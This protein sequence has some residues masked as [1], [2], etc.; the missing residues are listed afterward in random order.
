MNSVKKISV[1]L[2]LCQWLA[3]IFLIN[4][5]QR[6]HI[7]SQYKK[8][9]CLIEYIKNTKSD[10]WDKFQPSTETM[11]EFI[12]TRYYWTF[13][14]FIFCTTVI[15][16]INWRT[17][18]AIPN[19]IIVFI[20]TFLL[21]PTGFFNKGIVNTFLNSFGG[22]FSDNFGVENFIGGITFTIIGGFICWRIVKEQTIHN[23]AS[24]TIT[25]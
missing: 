25:R 20:L 8:Y 10:C 21:F 23:K 3:L 19:S 18:I 9:D 24:G 22:I 2:I 1:K 6:L 15:F 4:G 12:S 5:I 14:A 13:Y 16:F 17:K 11:E 7:S